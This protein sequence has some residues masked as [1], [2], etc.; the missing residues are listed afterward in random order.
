[1]LVVGAIRTDVA[2]D[3]VI[4]QGYRRKPAV[5]MAIPSSRHLLRKDRHNYARYQCEVV[6]LQKEEWLHSRRTRDGNC[7]TEAPSDGALRLQAARTALERLCKEVNGGSELLYG[8]LL[9]A[10]STT[11]LDHP[12]IP[13]AET[14]FGGLCAAAGL[15]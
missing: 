7:P 1:M 8:G 3:L 6:R 5:T 12:S 9:A 4:V 10:A 14:L 2:H 15:C 13:D 11:H